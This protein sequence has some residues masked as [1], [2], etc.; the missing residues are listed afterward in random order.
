MEEQLSLFQIEEAKWDP[1]IEVV[2]NY[3][4]V[5]ANYLSVAYIHAWKHSDDP[6]TKVGA[7]IVSPDFSEIIGIGANHFP[8]GLSPTD[9]ERENRDWKLK[10]IIHA[11]PSAIFHAA[12]YN[13]GIYTLDHAIM[14]MPWVP[15]TDCAKAIIDSGIEQIIGHKQMI[16]KTPKNWQADTDYALNLLRR[17][18]I[19]LYMHDGKIGGGTKGLFRGEVWEP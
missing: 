18:G 12:K 8:P 3:L 6:S 1:K 15:C 10:H 11:E 4:W 17:C 14:Y 13:C 19:K 5:H 9:E 16:M 2:N 7:V